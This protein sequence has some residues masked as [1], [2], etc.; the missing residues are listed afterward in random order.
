MLK[1]VDDSIQSKWVM[2]LIYLSLKLK[3]IVGIS[4]EKPVIVKNYS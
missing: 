3:T 4:L 2:A 1:I